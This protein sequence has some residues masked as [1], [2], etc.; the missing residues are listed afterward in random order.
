MVCVMVSPQVV[1]HSMNLLC[2]SYYVH[3][4]GPLYVQMMNST[5]ATYMCHTYDMCHK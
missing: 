1:W 3:I 2:V 4:L 5:Q